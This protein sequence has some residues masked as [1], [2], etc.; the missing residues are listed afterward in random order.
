MW[1]AGSEEA[2][3]TCRRLLLLF[4]PRGRGEII[5]KVCFWLLAPLK[6]VSNAR[7]RPEAEIKLEVMCAIEAGQSK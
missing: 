4:V 6:K 7:L 5:V 1:L 2:A 3:V